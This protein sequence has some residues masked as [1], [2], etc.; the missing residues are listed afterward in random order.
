MS[1]DSQESTTQRLLN[2]SIETSRKAIDE[3][4]SLKSENEQLNQRVR[5]LELQCE[6]KDYLIAEL[7]NAGKGN[8]GGETG[9]GLFK[10]RGSDWV[11]VPKQYAGTDGVVILYYPIGWPN[12]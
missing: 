9:A 5:Q 3:N 10:R 4:L 1:N 6:Q 2:T 8:C 12:K 11:Q 7:K